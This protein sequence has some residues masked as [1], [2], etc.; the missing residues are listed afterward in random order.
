ML[1]SAEAL[2]GAEP[3][4][5]SRRPMNVAFLFNAQDH[6]I[7]H[8]LPVACEL[9][10]LHP[11]M[12]VTVLV[13]TDEQLAL[14]ERLARF[15]PGHRLAFRRLRPP[16]PVAALGD[17][18]GNPKALVLWANRTLLGRFDALVVPERTTILLKR[19]GVTGP[20]FIH[21]AHGAGGADR[22][23]DE[24]LRRFDL[25]LMPNER[26]L[27]DIE[28]A[29]NARP[30][31]AAV[32][33]GVKMDLVRRMSEERPRLFPNDRPTVV[34][35]PHHRAGTTSWTAMGMAVLDHFAAGR[36]YNLVFAP[37]VRLFDPPR[38]HRARFRRF[39]GL[40]HVRIDLGSTASIDMTYTL[41]ADVYL[42]DLSSQ[43]LEFLV[44]PRPVLF[45]NPG[46]IGWRDDADFANWNLGPVVDSVDDM[47]AALAER[48]R[49]Q[50]GYADR[51]RRAFAAAFPT[52]AEP[53]STT[54]ARAI[55]AFL[56]DDHR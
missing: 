30:G 55:A 45:L 46:R 6:Q 36:D 4:R 49:W 1:S 7:P 26:R 8:G 19:M 15:H 24:R 31:R 47:A 42:G 34:Y 25:L 3:S 28:A 18:M 9:S 21:L 38:R 39:Q 41:G 23:G 29:G 52:L 51:Q 48:D 37:H 17:A 10:R 14:C 44:R 33:G 53:A 27:A 5:K 20:R 32:I 50:P 35:N 16:W 2:H 13:R 54:G 11:D 40:E 22:P 56:L 43:V 12:A